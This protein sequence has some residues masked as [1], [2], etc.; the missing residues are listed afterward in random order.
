MTT[1]AA[2][3]SPGSSSA[4]S[5]SGAATPAVAPEPTD[6]NVWLEEIYGEETLAWVRE[7][8]A[9]T[10]DLLED[11][12][13]AALEGSIL[14]VL[15]STDRIAMVGKRGDWYYNFWKDQTNP[16]GLW[17][18]TTWVSYLTDSPD[19]DVLL[20][21]DA[22]AADEGVEW[23][24]HG[25][26]FLRPAAGERYRIAL[27]A[28]SPDGGDANR[29]REFDVD[30]RIFVDPASGGFDL[31]TAK[32]NV[33]WLDAD[34]L[35]VASTAEGLPATASSYARTAVTLRR[36]ESLGGAPLLFEVPE[37]HMMAV[38]AHDS[39]PGFERTFA[40]D[41]IDFYNR[42]TYLRW[43]DAWTEIEA[44]TDVNLSAH[45]EWLLFRPQQDW[46]L[47]GTTYPAGSLLAANFAE[48][49]SGSRKLLT[50]FTPDVHTSLQSWSWT[51]NFLLLN[52]LRDVS[53][54]IRVL[55]PAAP[56]AGFASGAGAWASSLLDACPPLHDVNAYAVDDEDEGPTDGGAGDD[57]WLVAT[58][59]T[60]PSTL[61]RGTLERE[62]AASRD[63]SGS[64]AGVSSSVVSRHAEVKASP[65][66]FDDASYE[67]QQH[68]VVSED[69]TRVPY[70]QVASRNLVA[71]GQN[72]TQ[73]SGY[74]GFEVSRTPAY[75]GTVG[76]AWLE[77]RTTA[78][79]AAPH[80]R[81]GVFVVANIRGGGE[82]GPGW[83]RAALKENRH[84]AFE[85]FAAVARHLIS[86]GVTSRERLGCVGGSN[87]GLLVG[88]MLTTYP[89]LFGAVSCGVP[90]LDMR[91]YT[92]LSAGH[93]W[94]AEYGDPDVPAEWE[95]IKTF[96]PYHLLKDGVDYPETFI[97]TATSDDRVG[98]VQAR[99][100][101]ARMQAMGIP[102]VWFHEALEGGHAGA[103]DNRQ[104]AALQARSQHFLWRTLA[105]G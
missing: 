99:K 16:R 10:E 25:A 94:I 70:F 21:V 88:N 28:F 100:M 105:G 12:E 23:V 79:G 98:P 64:S 45:R 24:F 5:G 34:T 71:D 63:R 85:D 82:Y 76:R 72:P 84:R 55:D 67:V 27:L 35:L 56:A 2:D 86:R 48:Y 40:V 65:S 26:T 33:S 81:G 37:D 66:F 3:Q 53:S 57:F 103:S 90:L 22:L 89:E 7:Q 20:D 15:D 46:V 47:E 80:S 6:E 87:G 51:R 13:Y 30:T 9:R 49:L 83:H 32:G 11:A 62:A 14:A 92:K 42:S 74:G 58:G 54:E 78:T 18:R 75:S 44:P 91:R 69:G 77:R 43:D 39:T 59:F 73:L 17:R 93:S 68:F 1:T 19:W 50:L 52:L 8:N 41:Y 29:Y 96:S 36:G 95:Y 4:T 60:T 102:N 31:P 38:V 97:W 61:M 101:A 104:A